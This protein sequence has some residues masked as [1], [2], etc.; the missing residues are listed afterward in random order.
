[1]A[2][3][4]WTQRWRAHARATARSACLPRPRTRSASGCRRA[5]ASGIVHY[6]A[7]RANRVS[8]RNAQRCHSWQGRDGV[9]GRVQ[10]QGA[11]APVRTAPRSRACHRSAAGAPAPLPQSPSRCSAL[12]GQAGGFE[13]LA[14][15]ADRPTDRRRRAPVR[16]T[17]FQPSAMSNAEWESVQCKVSRAPLPA[18]AARGRLQRPPSTAR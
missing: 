8:E 10:R 14:A 4:R 13:P 7:R 2:L 15:V 1:M 9:C 17:T 16:C 5:R 12:W 6:A 18:G 3:L 11:L